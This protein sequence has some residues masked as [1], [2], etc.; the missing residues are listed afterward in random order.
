MVK[1]ESKTSSLVEKYNK[2]VKRLYDKSGTDKSD[3]L[4]E[5]MAK[6]LTLDNYLENIISKSLQDLYNLKNIVDFEQIYGI[7][8]VKLR[9]DTSIKVLSELIYYKYCNTNFY[10]ILI[11]ATKKLT[12]RQKEIFYYTYIERL[13][14]N[15]IKAKLGIETAT[16][17]S[18]IHE[19]NLTLNP[20]LDETY[21]IWALNDLF[22]DRPAG[23][24]N[25]IT[26]LILFSSSKK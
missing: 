26:K 25:E 16:L 21:S 22:K 8:E 1:K 6:V 15:D 9:L 4:A 24:S 13:E 17:T 23:L 12:K 3:K 10:R 5:S 19:I 7:D 11:K 18:H 14:T 2:D 20:E